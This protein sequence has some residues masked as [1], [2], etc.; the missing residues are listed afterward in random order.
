MA[1]FIEFNAYCYYSKYEKTKNNLIVNR[2]K[3]I[4]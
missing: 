1:S 3:I 2:T 4:L